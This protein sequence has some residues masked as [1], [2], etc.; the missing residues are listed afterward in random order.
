MLHWPEM[1]HRFHTGCVAQL[2]NWGNFI[3]EHILNYQLNYDWVRFVK[4]LS[5]EIIS[6]LCHLL[7]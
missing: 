6:N 5:S 3:A 7:S 2:K 1:S 4:K